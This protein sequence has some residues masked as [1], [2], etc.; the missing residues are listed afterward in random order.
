MIPYGAKVVCG[1]NEVAEFVVVAPC[2]VG[3]C[4]THCCTLCDQL[5]VFH[6]PCND[7]DFGTVVAI[8][9]QPVG[10]IRIGGW[11]GASREKADDS[12]LLHITLYL[13]D[14]SFQKR[15]FN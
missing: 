1:Q 14:A 2:A 5:V 15:Q 9:A 6:E 10:L 13:V 7:G 3:L 12:I 8:G 4:K 11:Y